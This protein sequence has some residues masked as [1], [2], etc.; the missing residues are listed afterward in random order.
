LPV[1]I[2]PITCINCCISIG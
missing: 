2:Y 1:Q